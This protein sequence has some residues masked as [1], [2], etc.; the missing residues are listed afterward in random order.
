MLKLVEGVDIVYKRLF[1][2][3]YIKKYMAE[4]VTSAMSSWEGI[5]AA[6]EEDPDLLQETFEEMTNGKF[7]QRL[8]ESDPR[9]T[10]FQML[11]NKMSQAI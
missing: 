6:L 9:Q 1:M 11:I 10:R 7:L 5:S 2:Q 3:D 8:K 4:K